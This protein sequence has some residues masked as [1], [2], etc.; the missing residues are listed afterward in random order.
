MRSDPLRLVG[1]SIPVAFATPVV[2]PDRYCSRHHRRRIRTVPDG[3]EGETLVKKDA[4]KRPWN[5]FD[6]GFTTFKFGA[7]LLYEYGAFSQDEEAKQQ[8]E[9]GGYVVEDRIQT[10]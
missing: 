10:A 8:A 4:P 6:L 7:G 3:T 1:Y 9:I 2:R 5:E